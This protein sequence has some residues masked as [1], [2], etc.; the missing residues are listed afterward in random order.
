MLLCC[1]D[2]MWRAL[3]ALIDKF[4]ADIKRTKTSICCLIVVLLQYWIDYWIV[5]QWRSTRVNLELRQSHAQLH[6]HHTHHR[7]T[8]YNYYQCR[9]NGP[10]Y[11]S[12][13]SH[14]VKNWWVMGQHL[15]THDPSDFRDPF[16]PWP[17]T[18]RPIPCS[19]LWHLCRHACELMFFWSLVMVCLLFAINQT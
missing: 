12:Q 11:I 18:H 14:R 3:K 6:T 10:Q 4:T 9:K 13:P 15:V 17:V 1:A 19:A 5:N 7:L 2:I 8:R 16:D